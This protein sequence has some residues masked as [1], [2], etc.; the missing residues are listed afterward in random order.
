MTKDFTP[1]LEAKK[2]IIEQISLN[3]GI[4]KE[5][6][7]ELI[8][9]YKEDIERIN[10]LQIHFALKDLKKTKASQFIQII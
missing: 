4:P 3:F 7:E 6:R 5:K 9:T 2:E 1:Y 8:A 10:R